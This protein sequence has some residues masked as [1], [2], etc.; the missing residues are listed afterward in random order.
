MGGLLLSYILR[1][2]CIVSW[3]VR[4][5]QS[6][7]G[8]PSIHSVTQGDLDLGICLPLSP[9]YWRVQVFT[10][11]HTSKFFLG[12]VMSS[13]KYWSF[14]ISATIISLKKNFRT[15]IVLSALVAMMVPKMHS[16]CLVIHKPA[17]QGIKNRYACYSCYAVFQV[18][19]WTWL[20][21]Q[22]QIKTG[23]DWNLLYILHV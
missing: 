1:S 15:S 7:H 10:P 13:P 17:V 14:G 12:L 5:S 21:D 9:M 20:S 18:V 16:R 2:P 8:W 3:R 19:Y 4:R 11:G 23:G 22:E 6:C